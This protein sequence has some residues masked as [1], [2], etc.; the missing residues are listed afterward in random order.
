[1]NG[2]KCDVLIEFREYP[3]RTGIWS[4][5]NTNIDVW[6]DKGM[7]DVILDVEGVEKVFDGEAPKYSVYTDKRYD[8]RFVAKEIEAAI[9][10]A[11]E[12]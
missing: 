4:E 8:I 10:C 6:A 7:K 11:D 1:M 5:S 9:L 3:D 2:R 12:V